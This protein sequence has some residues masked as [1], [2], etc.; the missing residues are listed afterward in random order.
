MYRYTKIWLIV[1]LFLVVGCTNGV[2]LNGGDNPPGYIAYA[3]LHES[4]PEL[5]VITP[6]GKE[7]RRIN[8]PPNV[9]RILPTPAGN[10][11]LYMTNTGQWFLVDT[12]E[13]KSYEL[14]FPEA[15]GVL[16]D[17][18]FKGGKQWMVFD[19]LYD[20]YLVSLADGQTTYLNAVNEDIGAASVS[21]AF[22]PDEEYLTLTS[23][24]GLWLIPTAHP[25]QAR[26]L[27]E[28]RI[29][30]GQESFSNDGAQIV[31]SRVT[32]E[33]QT[34]IVIEAVDGSK[35][36]VVATLDTQ[37]I[38]QWVYGKQQLLLIEQGQ[39][40]LLDLTDRISKVL[41][42]YE[43]NPHKG[44]FVLDGR[45]FVFGYDFNDTTSWALID[46]DT[47]MA[48]TSAELQGYTQ[49]LCQTPQQ[50]WLIFINHLWSPDI[51][52]RAVALE[53]ET[54]KVQPVLAW[55]SNTKERIGYD[56][57]SPNGHLSLMMIPAP[58]E[59]FQL[60]LLNAMDG[61]ARQLVESSGVNGVFSPDSRWVLVKSFDDK[62][63][64]SLSLIETDGEEIRPLGKGWGA[65]WVLP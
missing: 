34:E 54:G 43:G 45:K 16:P 65:V 3:T 49:I 61:K 30:T 14:M 57:P 33:A 15:R 21:G 39:L 1:M 2:T 7:V 5:V 25:D 4:Q 47:G 52:N 27:T 50:Q 46:L 59:S 11:V 13:G 19:K 26:Q 51:N 64:S 62:G 35:T 44:C 12:A 20:A 60:W 38:P 53:L 23:N 18:Q 36:D 8:L 42:N 10:R 6:D 29:A 40:S 22:S 31:Y 63:E 48:Q 37:A 58:Q 28:N 9:D 41:M 32:S 55:E 56:F 24:T 17:S